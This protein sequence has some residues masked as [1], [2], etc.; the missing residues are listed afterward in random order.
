MRV[1]GLVL[2]VLALAGCDD[3]GL[4]SRKHFEAALA[5][6]STAPSIVR[7][8]VVEGGREDVVCVFADDLIRAL[9]AE[10][11]LRGQRGYEEA[12]ALARANARQRFIFL[13]P[14]AVDV[15]SLNYDVPERRQGCAIIG[16]G[17]PAFRDDMSGEIREGSP[18]GDL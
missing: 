10:R 13:R 4:Q 9:M 1:F 5:N 6:S 15:L 8:K 17:R 16:R 3:G 2:L 14:Q 12:V 7:I 11:E 18:T